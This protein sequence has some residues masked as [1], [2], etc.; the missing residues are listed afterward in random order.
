MDV[1]AQSLDPSYETIRLNMYGGI[2]FDIKRDDNYV[3]EDGSTVW[4]R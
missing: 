3:M 1:N 2:D 4:V